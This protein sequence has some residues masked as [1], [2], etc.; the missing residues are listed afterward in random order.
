MTI[1]KLHPTKRKVTGIELAWRVPV[2]I[3][4]GIGLIIA[5]TLIFS[6]VGAIFGFMVLIP[7]GML[8]MLALMVPADVNCPHCASKNTINDFQH[9]KNF[10]CTSCEQLTIVSWKKPKA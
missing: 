4:G 5:I 2:G 7:A 3:L 8:L 10:K 6:L 1:Q 9:T